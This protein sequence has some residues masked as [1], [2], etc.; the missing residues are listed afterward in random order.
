VKLCHSLSFAVC[1]GFVGSLCAASEGA[2]GGSLTTVE[3]IDINRYMGR[4]YEVAKF[5]NWFQR[6]CVSDTRAEY[7]VAA[8]GRR[9]LPA[10]FYCA[11][12]IMLCKR[13]RLSRSMRAQAV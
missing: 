7:R 8:G 2:P 9:W 3:A 12:S 6:R 5:P 10:I 4:W 13:A 11:T 1:L